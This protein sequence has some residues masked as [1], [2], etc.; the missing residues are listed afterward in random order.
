MPIQ[1]SFNNI[2]TAPK[3][4]G[5]VQGDI[6]IADV[7]GVLT[8]LVKGT[9]GQIL[10][11]TATIPTWATGASPTGAAGGDLTGNY[12]NPTLG[13]NVVSF[14]KMQNIATG[15]FLGRNTASTGSIETITP[16]IARTMM[17]LG[18]AALV[19]TGTSSGNV[20]VLQG[21][22]TLDPALIPAQRSH[23]FVEVANAAARL[24]LTT[25][26]VQPG[27]EA[28][29]ID[30]GRTYKLTSADPTQASSWRLIADAIIDGSDIVSGTISV[31]RLGTGTPNASNFLRGDGSF[32]VP[33]TGSSF[34]WSEVTTTSASMSINTGYIA[35]NAARVSLSLPTV[36]AQGSTIR[37]AG[38]GAGGWRITQAA[39]QQISYLGQ[40]STAGVGGYIEA[41]LTLTNSFRACV[42]LLCTAANNTWLVTSGVG[43]VNTV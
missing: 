25:A 35:N 43:A 18:T 21:N 11:S 37:V 14:A 26:Q 23:E 16:A 27:D 15:V 28:Y 4:A 20:P 2:L 36:A 38:V 29:E 40:Q 7:N 33:A 10:I 12:P 30:T 6:F 41:E 1:N 31:N 5:A 34:S 42:E 9:P 17:G 3:V 32:A 24:A 19:N 8:S 22:G 13:T 39:G